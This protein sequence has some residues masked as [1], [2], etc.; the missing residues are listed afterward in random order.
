MHRPVVESGKVTIK[1]CSKYKISCWYNHRNLKGHSLLVCA[2][3][4]QEMEVGRLWRWG[5]IVKSKHYVTAPASSYNERKVTQYWP[6]R[7]SG[8]HRWTGASKVFKWFKT[9]S[10]LSIAWL[11]WVFIYNY[12]LWYWFQVTE[13]LIFLSLEQCPT[14]YMW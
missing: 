6:S 10:V 2:I 1:M 12:K 5:L 13:S 3:G 4:H 7:G 9:Q 8:W 11:W 14:S